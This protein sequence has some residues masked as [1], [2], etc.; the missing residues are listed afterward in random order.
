MGKYTIKER[1]RISPTTRYFAL[2]TGKE[3][4]DWQATSV[5]W[6]ETRKRPYCCKCS[7]IVSAM[8][9]SCKHAS[10]LRRYMRKP[11]SEKE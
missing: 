11:T 3:L 9:S 1:E 7:G 2:F 10:A 5:W 4:A 8:L 6:D